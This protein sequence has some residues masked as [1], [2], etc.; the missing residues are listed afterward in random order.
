[1]TR[2]VCVSTGRFIAAAG[3]LMLMVNGGV[4]DS[5][6]APAATP[7]TLVE[8]L[9][10][11]DFTVRDRASQQLIQMGESALAAVRAGRTSPDPE[12]KF[13]CKRILSMIEH[14]ARELRY[15]AFLSAS[16]DV[17]PPGGW[18]RFKRVA[19]EDK[20]ARR[21]FVDMHRAEWDLLETL[22]ESPEKMQ[23]KFVQRCTNLVQASQM[24]R[25]QLSLGS[26]ATI[27]F[28]AGEDDLNAGDYLG[29]SIYTFCYQSSFRTAMEGG[30]KDSLRKV[31]GRW[32]AS[33]T[34]RLT[35]YNGLMMAMR[36]ELPEGLVPAKRILEEAGMSHNYKQYALLAVGKLGVERDVTYL[37]K[38]MDDTMLCAT[39]PRRGE[40]PKY[41]TQIGDVALA[42]AIHLSG[43]DVKEFGFEHA[44]KNTQL[45]FN[46]NTLG[47]ES[48]EERAEAKRKWREFRASTR[49]EDGGE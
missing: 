35:A 41:A 36:Y 29:S 47:F 44:Q 34:S 30:Y 28:L 18:E 14:R 21:L 4:A 2:R 17:Q 25:Q 10:D 31:L 3:L 40:T 11:P 43:Q 16:T 13:A 24:L 27:L 33:T 19:G 1:M 12:I 45:L 9:G 48:D 46:A 26:V 32:V 8:Q 15:E 7:E 5:P 49:K 20:P 22:E 39:V 42:A 37:E 38:Y 6:A 23:Q